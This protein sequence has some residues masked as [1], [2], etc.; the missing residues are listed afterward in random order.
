MLYLQMIVLINDGYFS[1]RER[2]RHSQSFVNSKHWSRKSQ[3][4]RL[5]LYTVIMVENMSLMSLR[6]SVQQK[7]LNES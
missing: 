2:I 7:G 5:K 4:I 6:T 1:C 3:E